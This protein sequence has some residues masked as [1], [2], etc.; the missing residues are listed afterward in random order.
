V[1][2]SDVHVH[3]MP[4][5]VEEIIS[6]VL[7]SSD[8]VLGDLD[9]AAMAKGSR[10]PREHTQIYQQKLRNIESAGAGKYCKC[11]NSDGTISAASEDDDQ[12][13][14]ANDDQEIKPV[15]DKEGTLQAVHEFAQYLGMDPQTDKDFLWIAVEAMSAALPEN[16]TEFQTQ[17][18]QSYYYNRRTDT[19]QWE[20]PLDDYHRQLFMRL[21]KQKECGGDGCKSKEPDHDKK[22]KKERNGDRDRDRD[23]DNDKGQKE[24]HSKLK[25]PDH[26]QRHVCVCV[27]VCV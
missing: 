19:T 18:G 12:V 4:K 17:D 3:A 5:K 23:R 21:K 24:R 14:M 16:W 20:H 7:L 15:S 9:A 6:G 10:S 8:T 26:D 25:P 1:A 11:A 22:G 27:C 2:A 13:Q